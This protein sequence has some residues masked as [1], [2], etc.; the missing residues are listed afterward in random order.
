MKAILTLI[1]ATGTFNSFAGTNT[2]LMLRGFVPR[3]IST[4]I[5]H[6]SISSTKSLLTF[7]S[8]VNARNMREGQKFEV[9]GLNQSGLEAKLNAVVGSDR[10]IHYELF[11][12]RISKTI[13]E[14]KPI[15]LKI[16]AN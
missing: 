10:M 1:L 4:K 8:S 15:F 16:S 13:P 3:T 2:T 5:T 12:N 7:K 9:E 11:V 6:S 14:Y